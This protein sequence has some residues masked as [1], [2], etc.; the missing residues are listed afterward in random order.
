MGVLV[1]APQDDGEGM[2]IK[3]VAAFCRS[4]AGSHRLPPASTTL[5]ELDELDELLDELEL[6]E[7]ELLDEELDAPASF[8]APEELEGSPPLLLLLPAVRGSSVVEGEVAHA[9]TT[10]T[11]SKRTKERRMSETV[12]H[13]L[14]NVSS[15]TRIRAR[16]FG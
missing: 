5:P 15:L 9:N 10:V 4:F 12:T 2:A 8:T 1:Q 13:L 6:D 16:I 14:A 11:E 7:L 3:T